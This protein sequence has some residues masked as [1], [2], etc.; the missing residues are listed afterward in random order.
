[1]DLLF[2]KGSV[3]ESIFCKQLQEK[4]FQFTGY[5]SLQ[6]CLDMELK[7]LRQNIQRSMTGHQLV[8]KSTKHFF[9]A[10]ELHRLGL[11]R[12]LIDDLVLACMQLSPK[13][14]FVRVG[15]SIRTHE[16]DDNER[17]FLL[18]DPFKT[19]PDVIKNWKNKTKEEQHIYLFPLSQ[20]CN[21]FSLME[22]N[23]SEGY[24]HHYD[25]YIN[26]FYGEENTV[27]KVSSHVQTR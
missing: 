15:G 23:T 10:E 3:S 8:I 4:G 24:I 6:E 9:E 19:I 1:M 26:A 18:T 5:K 11:G 14:P 25:S 12:W 21:H 27:V 20:R 17:V 16:K 2:E 22:I 7:E 13:L